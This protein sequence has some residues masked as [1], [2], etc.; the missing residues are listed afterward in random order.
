MPAPPPQEV[1]VNAANGQFV[2]YRCGTTLQ[3]LHDALHLVPLWTPKGQDENK[4]Q[5]PTCPYAYAWVGRLHRALPASARPPAVPDEPLSP[6]DTGSAWLLQGRQAGA[7][8]AVLL[9]P[10]VSRGF[11]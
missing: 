4:A 8:R 1:T 9:R 11:E 6:A 10:P 5:L 3:L 2:T 7:G